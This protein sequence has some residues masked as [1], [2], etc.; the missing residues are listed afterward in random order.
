MGAVWIMPDVRWGARFT[1]W[2]AD[3]AGMILFSVLALAAIVGG[4][5]AAVWI[6]GHA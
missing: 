5:L 1:D 2:F 4:A 3:S 6:A